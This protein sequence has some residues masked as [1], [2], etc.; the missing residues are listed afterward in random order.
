MG[1]LSSRAR[2]PV[3]ASAVVRRFVTL[4]CSESGGGDQK[5]GRWTR[6]SGQRGMLN[7]RLQEL[8]E[9]ENEVERIQWCAAEKEGK[10]V[11]SRTL[12]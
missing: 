5:A 11:A 3:S 7:N 6:R 9:E 1:A 10:L 8:Q 4:P 12:P 2:L